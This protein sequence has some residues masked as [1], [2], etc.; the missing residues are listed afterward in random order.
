ML[1]RRSSAA[2]QRFLALVREGRGL[3]ASARAAGID[4]GIGYR[5]LREA[6]VELRDAGVSVVG[7]QHQLGYKS[8]LVAGW[9]QARVAAGP[10]RRHHLAV[11]RSLEDAFWG[12]LPARRQHRRGRPRSRSGR[13]DD[14]PVVAATVR[15]VTRGRCHGA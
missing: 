2:G 8:P 7:A 14:L 3:K 13:V 1:V 10:D 12:G 4:K 15:R 5:W 9:E 6:F 11:D